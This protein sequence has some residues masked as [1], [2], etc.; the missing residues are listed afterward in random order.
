MDNVV[1]LLNS[2]SVKPLEQ[3]RRSVQ[4]GLGTTITYVTGS[5]H[6][7][8]S[9]KRSS[10][11]VE[12]KFFERVKKTP[13]CWLWTGSIDPDGY[14]RFFVGR[15]SGKSK[16][17]FAHRWSYETFVGPIPDKMVI[18]HLAD[19]CRFRNCVNPAHLEPTT[20]G[21]NVSRGWEAKRDKTLHC[22]N[23]HEYAVVGRNRSHQCK[24]CARE[25]TKKWQLENLEESRK[26]HREAERAR[27]AK[28]KDE[29]NAR[30]RAKRAAAKA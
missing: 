4:T 20:G 10:G 1:E 25:A 5:A 23:G 19:R 9:G 30:R 29:I 16:N 11:T 17:V 27:R 14:G 22:P 8:R 26:A 21:D 18:D 7:R 3:T 15:V 24:Q 12:D 2:G 13:T 6:R 28:N